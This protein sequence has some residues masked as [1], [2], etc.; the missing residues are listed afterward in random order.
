MAHQVKWTPRA[1]QGFDNIIRYLEKNWTER[2]IS[3][4][5]S[6]T[7]A[8]LAI[9]EKNPYILEPSEKRKN[10]YRGPLNRLTIL[11]YRVKPQQNIIELL[12][13]RSAKQKPVK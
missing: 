12:N 2:E 10:V 6:E 3:N 11:T 4:F 1:K 5:I 13:I 7:K 8:F 9:L